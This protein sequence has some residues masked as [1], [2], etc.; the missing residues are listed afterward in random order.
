MNQTVNSTHD[1]GSVITSARSSPGMRDLLLA[2]SLN[3]VLCIVVII[4]FRQISL[5]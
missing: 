1:A 4:Q 2:L 3:A 5:L